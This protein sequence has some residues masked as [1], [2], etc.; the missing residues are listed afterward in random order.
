MQCSWLHHK[1]ALWSLRRPLLGHAGPTSH[2]ISLYLPKCLVEANQ[3][4]F[5]RCCSRLIWLH[6]RFS[7]YLRGFSNFFCTRCN[8]GQATKDGLIHYAPQDHLA[9]PF[10]KQRPCLQWT[11]TRFNGAIHKLWLDGVITRLARLVKKTP[12]DF[13]EKSRCRAQNPTTHSLC[14]VHPSS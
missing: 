3:K 14:L 12:K 4:L 9:G 10:W 5:G 6:F 2:S 1:E 13:H 8:R 11:L 7:T